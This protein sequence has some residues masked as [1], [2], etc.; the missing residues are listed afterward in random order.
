MLRILATLKGIIAALTLLFSVSLNNA[1]S[2]QET[3]PD[4]QALGIDASSL[5]SSNDEIAAI[6]KA[7][8][9]RDPSEAT[10]SEL[11][12]LRELA[13]GYSSELETVIPQIEAQLDQ[14][15]PEVLSKVGISQDFVSRCRGFSKAVD[16]A[17]DEAQRAE[18]LE[19]NQYCKATVEK[20][21]AELATAK[22]DAQ[23]RLG[24]IETEIAELEAKNDNLTEEEIERLEQLR[25]DREAT[26]EE[27]DEIS[28]GERFLLVLALFYSFIEFAGG[29]AAVVAGNPGGV[30]NMISGAAGMAK[31]WDGLQKGGHLP[32]DSGPMTEEDVAS[33]GET[34]QGEPSDRSADD[35]AADKN[36][37][38]DLIP[39]DE[40]GRYYVTAS[41]LG[42]PEARFRVYRVAD[43]T[44]LLD[45]TP[46]LISNDKD[47][48][49][50]NFI[51]ITR[52]A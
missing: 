43:D 6:L 51:A 30:V 9:V 17:V 32:P 12:K 19:E 50:E 21:Q 44:L 7:I 40:N 2:A 16:L 36:F 11:A 20:A 29:L 33:V 3:F 23:S 1:A 24:A 25:K 15:I 45:L 52:V 47:L 8:E 49:I 22:A 4:L 28:D 26:K 34:M 42:T 38:G 41:D 37:E 27:I 5:K 35:I 31:A 18:I 10:E 13:S 14:P 39:T 46:D 48:G